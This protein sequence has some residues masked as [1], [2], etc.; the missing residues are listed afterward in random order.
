MG[1][2]VKK[3]CDNCNKLFREL[4]RFKGKFYCGNC[5]KSKVTSIPASR[6]PMYT[7]EQALKRTYTVHGYLYKKFIHPQICVPQVLI[8]HK[9][10]LILCDNEPD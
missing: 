8:G 6:K 1:K 7:L 10:K 4:T 5:L 2:L 9:V 3:K